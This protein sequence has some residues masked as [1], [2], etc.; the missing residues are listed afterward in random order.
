M[1]GDLSSSAAPCP[2]SSLAR[3]QMGREKF[4]AISWRDW[5]G[6]GAEG[7]LTIDRW[8]S[9]AWPSGYARRKSRSF[10]SL[11]N[12]VTDGQREEGGPAAAVSGFSGLQTR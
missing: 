8:S 5:G 9:C 4:L 3:G 11:C 1:G 2:A 6:A 7:D 10:V 12:G